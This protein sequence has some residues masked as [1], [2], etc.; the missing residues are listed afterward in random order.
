MESRDNQTKQQK[1]IMDKIA[2]INSDQKNIIKFR[3]KTDMERD[4]L[5]KNFEKRGFYKH[6]EKDN[7]PWNIYWTY[8]WTVKNMFNSGHRLGELQ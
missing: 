8:P 3:Y 5:I 6:F 4:V 1:K 2:G 7:E